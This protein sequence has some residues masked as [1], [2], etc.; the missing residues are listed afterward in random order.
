M[1]GIIINM[2]QYQGQEED[3]YKNFLMNILEAVNEV[4]GGAGVWKAHRKIVI[5]NR[6]FTKK[7]VISADSNNVQLI[8]RDG[9]QLLLQEYRETL[10]AKQ[11]SR[12]LP[13]LKRHEG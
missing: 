10:E 1:E 11:F 3:H 7:A 8:D 6:Y 4:L 2:F 12:F 5:T 9:L 13:F